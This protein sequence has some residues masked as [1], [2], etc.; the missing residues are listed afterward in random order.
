MDAPIKTASPVSPRETAFE[1]ILAQW[2]RVQD[3]INF[4]EGDYP[5]EVYIGVLGLVVDDAGV[6]TLRTKDLGGLEPSLAGELVK[7]FHQAMLDVLG[8]GTPA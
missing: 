6:V 8:E 1:K 4:V 7:R 3:H 2:P 5:E